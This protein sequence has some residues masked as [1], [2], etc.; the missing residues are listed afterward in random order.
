MKISDLKDLQKI[1]K[2]M[3]KLGILS[4]KTAEIEISLDPSFHPPSRNSSSP[5]STH[6]AVGE[7]IS[8]ENLKENFKSLFPTEISDEDLLM[9]SAPDYSLSDEELSAVDK[10]KEGA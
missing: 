9:W 4:L 5:Q 1:V 3:R 6:G 2:T 10:T 7:P 8:A